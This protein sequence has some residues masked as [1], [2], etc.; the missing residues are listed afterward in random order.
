MPSLYETEG[1]CG[2]RE[3]HSVRERKPTAWESG[4]A[5]GTSERRKK[6]KEKKAEI[7]MERVREQ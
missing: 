1:G 3:E 5:R 4:R 2:R 6:E 7:R